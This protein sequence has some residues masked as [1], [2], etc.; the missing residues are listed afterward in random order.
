M[1]AD[2]L[3]QA[4]HDQVG[5]EVERARQ[6]G[7]GEG[8]VHDDPAAGGVGDLGQG[9]QVRHAQQRV[10]D[11]LDVEDVGGGQQGGADLVGV[12]DVD[13]VGVDAEAAELLRQELDGAAVQAVAGDDAARAAEG[14]EEGGG[15]GGHAGGGDQAPVGPFHPGQAVA[16]AAGVGVAVAG[17]D[18]AG[19]GAVGDAVEDVEV[20]QGVDGRLVER[21]HQR[22]GGAEVGGGRL[23]HRTTLAA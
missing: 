15:D 9:R 4:L 12:V 14:T 3:G 21:R 20:G 18:V 6:H 17:V 1:A 5:A 10:G 22:R 16:E 7:R 13:E 19:L 11:G 23:G 2:H 8:V